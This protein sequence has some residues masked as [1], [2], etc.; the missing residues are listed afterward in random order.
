MQN[1]Y[2]Q[3]FEKWFVDDGKENLYWFDTE[4]EAIAA[5]EEAIQWYREDAELQD[6]IDTDVQNIYVGCVVHEVKLV[7][8]SENDSYKIEIVKNIR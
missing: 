7:N 1:K 6:K 5:M 4:E 3:N 8:N 2:R